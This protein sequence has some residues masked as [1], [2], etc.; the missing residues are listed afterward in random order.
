MTNVA[1]GSPAFE[2]GMVD[3][4]IILEVDNAETR[5]IEDLVKEVY[6][7]KVGDTVRIFAIRNRREHFFE[8][9]FS[10]TP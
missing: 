6:K 4:D 10:Q 8:T 7:R 3:G 2:A 9:R 5:R 1:E